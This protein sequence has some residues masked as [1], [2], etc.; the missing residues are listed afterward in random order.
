M[1]VIERS[2]LLLRYLCSVNGL[3]RAAQTAENPFADKLTCLSLQVLPDSK[4]LFYDSE[5]TLFAGRLWAVML[6]T[7]TLRCNQ[8]VG[9]LPVSEVCPQTCCEREKGFIVQ[10]LFAV[11]RTLFVAPKLRSII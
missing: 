6:L 5:R 3:C 11:R 7:L 1:N 9:F 8:E 4:T 10:T 2:Y